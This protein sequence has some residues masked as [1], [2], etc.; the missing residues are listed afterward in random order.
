MICVISF[1]SAFTIEDNSSELRVNRN[2][3]LA[4]N[5]LIYKDDPNQLMESFNK[6]VLPTPPEQNR[7]N[8]RLW[9]N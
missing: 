9:Q 5:K 8:S 2:S 4:T 1:G 3:S 7:K 6:V